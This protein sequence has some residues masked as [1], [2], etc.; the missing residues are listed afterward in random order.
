MAAA[1]DS[2]TKVI[3]I[4]LYLGSG[5]AIL[6]LLAETAIKRQVTLAQIA[7]Y[8]R[9]AYP[10]LI[11]ALHTHSFEHRLHK[12]SSTSTYHKLAQAEPVPAIG[13]PGVPIVGPT[14]TPS[15]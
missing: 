6:A 12:N 2:E 13:P 11:Y 14:A 9:S 4:A 1:P 5:I 8:I 15:R 7:V 3:S 10:M